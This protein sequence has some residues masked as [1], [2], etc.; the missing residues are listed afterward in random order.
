[1]K[2]E[3]N[4]FSG[5]QLGFQAGQSANLAV[6]RVPW[7]HYE[8]YDIKFINNVLHD[9]PGVGMSISGAY[10]ALL[11]HNT[12]YRVGTSTANGFA[13]SQFV[14]GER[15]CTPTDDIP[16]PVASCTALVQQGAWGPDFQTEN[17]SAISNRN[18]YVFNNIFFNPAPSQTL[19]SH[20]AAN[21]PQ[22]LPAGF[23]NAPAPAKTDDNLVIAGNLIWN[24][25]ADHPLGVGNAGE[26]C[27]ASNPTCN[28]AQLAVSNT[29]NLLL[30]QLADPE[31]GDFRPAA[32]G[33]V[34]TAT[35]YLAPS[36]TWSDAPAAPA[37]PAGNLANTISMDRAGSRRSAAS[38]PGAYS[39]FVPSSAGTYATYLPVVTRIYSG[40]W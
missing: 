19:Y 23:R 15:G 20:F 24:G 40:G 29:V 38:P 14:Q 9:I 4:E 6:M 3:G 2:V 35:T 13:L 11:A 36:F 8:V 10:N 26:G 22:A 1:M 37:V 7:L 30:P 17:V 32:G 16:D 28:P 27:E 18:I 25:P 31:H 39:A 5:C 12:L 34:F 21:G 33:N